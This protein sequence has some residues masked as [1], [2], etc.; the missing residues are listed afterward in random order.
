MPVRF[1][2]VRLKVITALTCLISYFSFGQNTD[3]YLYIGTYTRQ[4][5]EGIYVYQFN[6]KTG[7]FK[8]VSITKGTNPSFLSISSD[9][10]FLYALAGMK[11][12]S[13]KAF[14][15]EKPSHHLTLLNS[16][17]LDGSFGA[18]HLAVDKTGRWLIVGNYGSGSLNLLPI[19]PDG[20]LGK[21]KQ[22]IAHEGKSINA[23]RQ[24]KPHVHSINIS[25]NNKDVFV[26]DL[27]TD[28]IMTYALNTETGELANGKIPFTAVAAG[29]GPRH[30][31][32]HPNGK[33]TYVIQ[34]LNST[35]TAFQYVDGA[36]EAFQTAKT[37]PEEYTGLNWSADIHIS[38]DGKSLYASNRAHESLTIFSIDK[39]TGKLTLA[40]RQPVLGKTPRNFAIDPTGNFVLVANQDSDNIVIFKRDHKTG[41]LTPTGKEIVI[42]QPVCL[43]FIP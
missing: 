12:D 36:L 32:F 39:K 4:T 22:T 40:G 30:F 19:Q 10:R 24:E 1:T 37:L 38:P 6:S 43:K 33:W 13:V 34:E 16:Q 26:P 7:D 11:G 41:K 5:S 14:A 42:S 27:G 15:I 29:S 20:M 9:Q 25:P 31:T 21:V 18:C 8:P 28:K 23:E 17:S 3:Y 2:T 35:V